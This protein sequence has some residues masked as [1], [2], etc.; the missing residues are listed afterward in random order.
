MVNSKT[1]NINTTTINIV[2]SKTLI[3]FPVQVITIKPNPSQHTIFFF[4][5]QRVNNRFFLSQIFLSI[6]NKKLYKYEYWSTPTHIQKLQSKYE[7]ISIKSYIKL[8]QIMHLSLLKQ[9][10]MCIT[11]TMFFS[12]K[13][14]CLHAT[15]KSPQS[16][17][18]NHFP[19][20]KDFSAYACNQPF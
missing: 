18:V 11:I 16:C 4:A 7:N 20:N 13:S 3:F 14:I 5:G 12:S 6:N 17:L 9:H 1:L 19:K 15:H 10:I 2:N 8:L